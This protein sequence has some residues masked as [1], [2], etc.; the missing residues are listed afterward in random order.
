LN[1][2]SHRTKRIITKTGKEY[3][4]QLFTKANLRRTLIN[5]VYKGFVAHKEAVYEGEHEGILEPE[6]FHEVQRVFEKCPHIRGR[7]S[8]AKD[9]A[10]LK[11]LIR[12]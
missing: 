12:C 3:G 5:P 6:F 11:N 1:Q 10:L 8:W 4:A 7:E 2:Q 9:Q